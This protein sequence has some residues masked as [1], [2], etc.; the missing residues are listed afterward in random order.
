[1][2]MT[3]KTTVIA[4]SL[5][6]VFTLTACSGGNP[7]SSE[8]QDK[9]KVFIEAASQAAE[10]QLS[11]KAFPAGSTYYDCM[12]GNGMMDTRKNPNLCE[13]LYAAMVSYAN[14]SNSAYK[15]ITV[16]DLKDQKAFRTLYHLPINN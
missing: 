11:V 9:T 10:K 2:R 4:S 5:L 16:S 8:P 1:M 12:T 14:A 15:D 6:M 7:M 3:L 13:D